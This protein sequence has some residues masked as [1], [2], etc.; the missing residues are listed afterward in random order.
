MTTVVTA[1]EPPRRAIVPTPTRPSAGASP[2]GCSRVLLGGLISFAVA[3]VVWWLLVKLDRQAPPR[4]ARPAR[5]SATCS[6]TRRRAA[7]RPGDGRGRARSP[8]ATR[9]SGFFAGTVRGGLHACVFVLRR[10]IEQAT[11][12]LAMALR[13]VPLV[14]LTPLI[15][16]IFG[17][18]LLA[19]TVIAGIVTFFPTLVNVTLGAPLGAPRAARP[20]AGLRRQRSRCHAAQGAVPE[21]AAGAVR[22]ACASPRRWRSSAPCSPSGWPPGRAWAT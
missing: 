14:A 8:S 22:L 6:P 2:S 3:M 21:L 5:C 19:V 7:N 13:T 20:H 12:P 4:P 15:A 17:R 16:L 9:P 10:G 11:M 1:P 18:G